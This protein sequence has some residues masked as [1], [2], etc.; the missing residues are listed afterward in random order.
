[1][2][3]PVA[4]L[5]SGVR[6]CCS[7]RTNNEAWGGRREAAASGAAHG[8]CVEICALIWRDHNTARGRQLRHSLSVKMGHRSLSLHRP[9]PTDW[10]ISQSIN[11]QRL[12]VAPASPTST[13]EYLTV[14]AAAPEGGPQDATKVR[15]VH[16]PGGCAVSRPPRIETLRVC[17]CHLHALVQGAQYPS[18]ATLQHTQ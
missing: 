6:S 14:H 16:R 1:V 17:F 15:Q 9:R 18:G 12:S 11:T 10:L 8:G 13:L 3:R 7:D 5:E 2:S 4:R